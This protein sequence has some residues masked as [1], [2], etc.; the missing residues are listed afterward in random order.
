MLRDVS[1]TIEPG[2]TVAVVGHTGAGKTTLTNLLLRF[3]DVQEGGITFDGVDIR[4]LRLRDLRKNFGIV[5][6]DPFLFS[7]T[8]ASNIRLGSEGSMTKPRGR[9][10]AGKRGR[11][12]LR[13]CRADSTNPCAERGATLSIGQ[14]QLLSFARALA[15]NPRILILDE[16][17]SSVDPEPELRVREACG[18]WW[19]TVPR[20][21]SRTGSPPF[22]V[23]TRSW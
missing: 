16:A 8:M 11:S 23:R 10:R 17:T 18:A 7:G 22:K 4:E 5:L 21:S 19:R 1:F 12:L 13:A 14:K 15:H 3:Y 2:E 9:C 6:Q 20:S